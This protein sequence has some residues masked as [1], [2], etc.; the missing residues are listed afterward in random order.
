MAAIVQRGL[1]QRAGLKTRRHEAVKYIW[2]AC[3]R[4]T[5][6]RLIGGLAIS[7]TIE[8]TYIESSAGANSE[9]DKARVLQS[10]S[11]DLFHRFV[12]LLAWLRDD[13]KTQEKLSCSWQAL[14]GKAWSG[15]CWCSPLC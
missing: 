12:A 6:L 14:G 5:N 4:L 10:F 3:N 2:I 9:K 7:A 13:I 1:G 15:P 11:P 8:V